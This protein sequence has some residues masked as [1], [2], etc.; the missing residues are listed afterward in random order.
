[1]NVLFGDMYKVSYGHLVGAEFK[2]RKDG[3]MKEHQKSL[4]KGSMKWI[5]VTLGHAHEG[6]C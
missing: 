4:M 6:V 2:I 3:E 1:M 5:H